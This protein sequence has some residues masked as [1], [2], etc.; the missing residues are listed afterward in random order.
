MFQFVKIIKECKIKKNYNLF[1]L[2]TILLRN[3]CICQAHIES[4]I[5]F[6]IPDNSVINIGD[7]MDQFANIIRD[8]LNF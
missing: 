4:G 5:C 7:H 1:N 2:K 8:N 3:T 6:V